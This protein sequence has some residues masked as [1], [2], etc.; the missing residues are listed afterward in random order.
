VK[1]VK[2]PDIPSARDQIK[3]PFFVS[4][5]WFAISLDYNRYWSNLN[6]VPR[7]PALYDLRAHNSLPYLKF[8]LNGFIASLRVCGAFAGMSKRYFRRGGICRF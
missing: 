5:T 8:A 6:W 2:E 7:G 4:K 1:V 3:V